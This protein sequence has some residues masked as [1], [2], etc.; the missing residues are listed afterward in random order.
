MSEST[1]EAYYVKVY[2]EELG[3]KYIAVGQTEKGVIQVEGT[4]PQTVWDD[5]W[6]KY[7]LG[8]EEY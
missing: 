1:R 3:G 7:E 6:L 2:I 4:S 8:G 5:W